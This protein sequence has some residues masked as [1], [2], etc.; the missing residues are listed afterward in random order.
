MIQTTSKLVLNVI[1]GKTNCKNP[2]HYEVKIVDSSTL[3]ANVGF[4]TNPVYT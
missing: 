4:K 1:T 2:N 3:Q